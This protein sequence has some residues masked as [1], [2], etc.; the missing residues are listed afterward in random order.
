MTQR[1]KQQIEKLCDEAMCPECEYS[2][3]GLSGEVVVCPECGRAIDLVSLLNSRWEGSWHN[4]PTFQAVVRPVFMLILLLIGLFVGIAADGIRNHQLIGMLLSCFAVT[5]WGWKMVG[6]WRRFKR[7]EAIKLSLLAILVY[8]GYL[9][10]FFCVF[11]I[12][13]ALVSPSGIG[14]VVI[15][16]VLFL[17]GIAILVTSHISD[18]Y[19][20]SQCVRLYLLE[21]ANLLSSRHE[22]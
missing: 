2:L 14:Q 10:G 1:G 16:V 8:A 5:M 7:I 17:A 3:R 6:V 12:L 20:A 11:M 4:L 15:G 19:L 18:R 9:L 21:Q 22:H 13:L